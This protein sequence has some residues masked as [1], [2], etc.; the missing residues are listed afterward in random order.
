VSHPSSSNGHAR[1]PAEQNWRRHPRPNPSAHFPCPSL[2]STHIAMS[3]QP[4]LPADKRPSARRGNG[5]VATSSAPHRRERPP[6]GG[7]AIVERPH[8]GI[9]PRALTD[10]MVS[11]G[12]VVVSTSCTHPQAVHRRDLDPD[13]APASGGSGS[14]RAACRS[15]AGGGS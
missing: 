12:S 3:E 6:L 9:S 5:P 8:D 10:E 1:N 4:R 2:S 13:H 15:G 14:T 11:A 7:C